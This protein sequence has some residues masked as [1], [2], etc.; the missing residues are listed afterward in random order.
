[1]V[2]RVDVEWGA[3]FGGESGKVRSVAVEEAIAVVEGTWAG[4]CFGRRGGDLF[5]QDL[6]A[7]CWKRVGGF[8]D[9]DPGGDVGDGADAGEDDHEGGE[10]ADE[11]EIPTIVKGK[12]CADSGDH[13][14]VARA[15]ELSCGRVT[16][17]GRWNSRG[18]R[19]AG[20]TETGGRIDF[21]ATLGTEH[22]RLRELLFCHMLS[23]I[24]YAEMWLPVQCET[25][26]GCLLLTI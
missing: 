14:V 1:L 15:G 2:R 19:S 8:G 12:A 7:L 25:W 21:I 20:G 23:K 11:V 22:G 5:G 13:A 18:G 24:E 6:G 10:D 4:L 16:A 17:H 9:D 26:L 3:V